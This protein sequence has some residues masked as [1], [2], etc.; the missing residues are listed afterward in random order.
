MDN[1]NSELII[2]FSRREMDLLNEIA[3]EKELSVHDL[4]LLSVL[5]LGDKN[6]K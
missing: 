6:P 5:A 3:K 1:N 4:I 2:C